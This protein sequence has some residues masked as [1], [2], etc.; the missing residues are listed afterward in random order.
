MVAHND[1]PGDL[2]VKKSHEAHSLGRSAESGLLSFEPAGH[3]AAARD[4]LQSA[5]LDGREILSVAGLSDDTKK[6]GDSAVPHLSIIDKDKLKPSASLASLA[7]SGVIT[8]NRAN[9]PA[10][11]GRP[12]TSYEKPGIEV[13]FADSLAQKGKNPDLIV[14][15]DGQVVMLNDVEKNST[16]QITIGLERAQGA[17]NP[18]DAQNQSVSELYKYLDARLKAQNPAL[19]EQGIDLKNDQN[20]VPQD[21]V[22]AAQTRAQQQARE[23]ADSED[24][25]GAATRG[26]VNNMNRFSGNGGG[27]M[28]RGEVEDMFPNRNFDQRKGKAD[29]VE[30]MKD[31][32]TN[33]N[34]SKGDYDSVSYRK[35]KGWTVGPYGMSGDQMS[36]Y[37]MGVDL[38]D[39]AEKEAKGLVPP[40]TTERMRKMQEQ[41]KKGETPD[42]IKK[43]KEG[44][45]DHPPDKKEVNQAFGK[46]VQELAATDLIN[47]YAKD[48][49]KEG[50][51][52]D[53]SKIALAMHL[54]RTPNAEDLKSSDNQDY[55]KAAG[56]AWQIAAAASLNGAD[57]VDWSAKNGS[58]LSAAQDAQGHRMWTRFAGSVQGGRLG[59]AASV[60]EVLLNAGVKVNPVA[61]A[62]ALQAQLR[63]RGWQVLPLDQAKPGDVIYGGKANAAN[64][65]GNAHIGI[66]ASNRNGDIKVYA[67]SSS[68]GTWKYNSLE[69]AF[70]RNRFGN[71]RF[72]LRPPGSA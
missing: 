48:M 63:E 56:N 53:P 12:I 8:D 7:E 33:L 71:N 62:H 47:K 26:Q 60:S 27:R 23:Q 18:T 25:G 68:S 11:E 55:M 15:A 19:A 22:K 9:S 61:G 45:K 21:A 5:S 16:G 57:G 6:K 64:G 31:V 30:V 40:G 29:G 58:I 3:A 67:N 51:E 42:I 32:L 14:K 66:I 4:R 44:D 34:G 24:P 1:A 72:V 54:G 2:P 38:N 37:I 50:Q 49:G 69:A 39:L 59:C 10:I 20:L 17:I 43:M 70:N 13:A 28:S 36:A 41:L 65:G 52:V 46:E 35:G